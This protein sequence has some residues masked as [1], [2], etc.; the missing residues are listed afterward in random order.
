MGSYKVADISLA[1]WGQKEVILAR[2]EMPGLVEMQQ[3]FGDSKPLKGARIAGC[4]HMTIQTAVLIETL[5]KLGAEVAW[6]SCN[7]FSTQDHA[8]AAVATW[9]VP[10]Y[11]WKGETVEEYITHWSMG[12]GIYEQGTD[13]VLMIQVPDR[14]GVTL[15]HIIQRYV[16][17][18]TT[19][20]SDEWTDY[21]VVP[22][23]G[24]D[25]HTVNHSENFVDPIDG[26]HTQGIENAW[27]VVK[28][29]QRRG[30]T[31]NPELL[32]SHLI[33]SCW[34]RKNKGNILNSI[35]KCIRELY[36]VV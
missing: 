14:S 29:R 33:E 36:P 12:F 28:K 1:E 6:S 11:A 27:G 10:V 16:L 9:G 34:R 3:R 30:Q 7:I 8:A 26:T 19:I 2:N 31:T 35:V 17:P 21:N 32:E 4:L 25:H 23:A 5:R 24:Y 22:A 13:N 20:H 15:L 18:G